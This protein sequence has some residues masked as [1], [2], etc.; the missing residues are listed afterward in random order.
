M[1]KRIAPIPPKYGVWEAWKNEKETKKYLSKYKHRLKYKEEELN[2]AIK[3]P[4]IVHFTRLKP[5]W[6]KHTAFYKEWWRYARLT[7]YYDLIYTK[8]P[9]PN[10][11][12][13]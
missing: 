8:S 2:Y 7:G 6:K 13:N 5:F 9:N 10:K 11:K 12:D 4:A 3:H 1:Q